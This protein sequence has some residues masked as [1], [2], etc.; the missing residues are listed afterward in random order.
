MKSSI[1]EWRKYPTRYRG[2]G[3]GTIYS[4]SKVLVASRRFS[5]SVPYFVALIQL[6]S[7]EKITSHI[8]D[9]LEDDVRIGAKVRPVFRKIGIDSP[10]E[11]IAYGTKFIVVL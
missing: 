6:D 9:T 2:V 3:K 10:E 11:S 8:V 1:S 4:F 7:G 5:K